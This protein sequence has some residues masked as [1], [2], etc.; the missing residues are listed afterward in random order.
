[1]SVAATPEQNG[2]KTEENG[3]DA[4]KGGSAQSLARLGLQ[5][6]TAMSIETVSPGRK[7]NVRLIGFVE[8]KSILVSSPT[9][10]GK[11]VLLEK[12]NPMVVRLLEGKQICAFE[13]KVLY[14]SVHPYVY[15]HLAW[16]E[17]VAARQIRDSERIDTEFAVMIDNEFDV[18]GDW[19]KPAL[20]NNLSK[21]GAR[22][23]ATSAL[24]SAGHEVVIKCTL[25]MSE[26]RKDLALTAIIRNVSELSRQ[27]ASGRTLTYHVY[28][29][30]FLNVDGDTRLA[31][32]NY[33][34]ENSRPGY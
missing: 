21:S 9:R 8:G 6:G 13:T 10:D 7:C 24:G 14:R 28:G 29:V 2:R 25:T 16:P 34:Y 17:Q 33:I 22:I 1:V 5:I 30:Q 3:A 31:L 15:Y 32:A 19:P 11:D 18:V 27:D 20:L 4:N 26:V 23:L 12:D